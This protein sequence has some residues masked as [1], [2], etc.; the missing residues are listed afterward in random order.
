MDKAFADKVNFTSLMGI[1]HLKNAEVNLHF[2]MIFMIHAS[3]S[4]AVFADQGSSASQMTAAKDM[5]VF[6]WMHPLAQDKQRT[7]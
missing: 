6:S 7:Q 4:Y 3:G 5:D 1:C 2:E